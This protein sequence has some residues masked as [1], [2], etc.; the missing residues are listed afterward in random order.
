MVVR[1]QSQQQ[2][3]TLDSFSDVLS[4]R[5]K[6]GLGATNETTVADSSAGTE[7]NGLVDW[8]QIFATASFGVGGAMSADGDGCSLEDIEA[9]LVSRGD[10]KKSGSKYGS[11]NSNNSANNDRDT[12]GSGRHTVPLSHVA[13]T[14]SE[15]SMLVRGISRNRVE[16]TGV[17]ESSLQTNDVSHRLEDEKSMRLLQAYIQEQRDDSAADNE[18]RRDLE[19]VMQAMQSKGTSLAGKTHNHVPFI[20]I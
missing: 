3:D 20:A 7:E 17:E 6:D 19:I 8:G 18:S 4:T 14:N 12:S 11:S 1:N 5:D 13:S 9:M 10:N 16:V 15:E 2:Y